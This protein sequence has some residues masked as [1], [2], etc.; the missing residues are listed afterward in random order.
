[1]I[2]AV[3]QLVGNVDFVRHVL[4]RSVILERITGSR[5]LMKAG[6]IPSS[7]M[8]FDLMPLIASHTSSSWVLEK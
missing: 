5:S 4:K 3:F 6:E 7:P 8:A 2:F 1:M